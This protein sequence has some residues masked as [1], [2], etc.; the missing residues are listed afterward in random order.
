MTAR[1]KQIN[2]LKLE[3][4]GLNE[5]LQTVSEALSNITALNNT[6]EVCILVCPKGSDDDASNFIEI[7]SNSIVKTALESSIL[8]LKKQI[9][10]RETKIVELSQII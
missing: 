1:N 7:A 4:H 8:L 6:N 2:E 10:D 3:I 5:S 9:T